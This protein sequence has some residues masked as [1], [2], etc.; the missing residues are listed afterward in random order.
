MVV[1]ERL[2]DNYLDGPEDIVWE[3]L[4]LAAQI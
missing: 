3:I 2:H 4:I 1:Q